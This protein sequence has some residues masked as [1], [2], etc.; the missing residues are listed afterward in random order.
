MR[1]DAQPGGQPDAPI[2]GFYLASVGA[3]RR[4]PYSLGINKPTASRAMIDIILLIGWLA[5]MATMAISI[6]WYLA[7]VVIIQ[8]RLRDFA[9]QVWESLGRPLAPMDMLISTGRR[10][11]QFLRSREYRRVVDQ[12]IVNLC[13]LCRRLDR[14]GMVSFVLTLTISVIVAV[15]LRSGAS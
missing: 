4:L 3:A 15:H 1:I 2:H 12:R 14:I 9:P 10:F 13:E 8:R 11:G 5:A 6:P 7:L